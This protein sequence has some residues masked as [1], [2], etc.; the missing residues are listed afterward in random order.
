MRGV[1]SLE[2]S[3]DVM[4]CFP[5]F[6]RNRE[7]SQKR[8][9]TYF[10]HSRIA[11]CGIVRKGFL[12][13]RRG[14]SSSFHFTPGPRPDPAPNCPARRIHYLHHAPR[15]T[16]PGFGETIGNLMFRR[17]YWHKGN[18]WKYFNAAHNYCVP[19]RHPIVER[20]LKRE[21]NRGG[22]ENGVRMT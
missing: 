11:L 4:F 2:R 5:R 10:Y 22:S 3:S 12:Q 17:I 20:K 1:I 8:Q 7:T 21:R 9:L 13:R 6:S 19:P 18:T 16:S 15:P 14:D